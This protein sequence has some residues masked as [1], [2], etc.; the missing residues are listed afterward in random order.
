MTR[1]NLGV[2]P[3]ELCDKHLVAE[4]R[5]IPRVVTLCK[6]RI[7]RGASVVPPVTPER[8]VLG[9]GHMLYFCR[10]LKTIELRYIGLCEEMR[11]RGFSV[12]FGGRLPIPQAIHHLVYHE[13]PLDHVE[14]ARYL[15]IERIRSRMP[16]NPR[17]TK[18]TRYVA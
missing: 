1:V 18:R 11:E 15:V 10:F 14:E 3:S 9:T 8:F 6:S 5:E 7:S 16:S 2:E 12:N 17:H 4:Y 13:C